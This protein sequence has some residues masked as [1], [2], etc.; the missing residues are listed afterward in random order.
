MMKQDLRITVTKRIMQEALLQMLQKKPIDK[1]KVNELCAECGLNRAT[2]Y[3]HYETVNEIL[4]EIELDFIHKMPDPCNM[5]SKKENF[6]VLAEDICQYFYANSNLV[7]ILLKNRSDEE[8]SGYIDQIFHAYFQNLKK[9]AYFALDE[10]SE[11]VFLAVLGG[12]GQRLLRK[13]IMGEIHK[14][15]Q[16]IAT[17]LC[18][19]A[20]WVQYTNEMC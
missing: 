6:Q 3:R 17:I 11:M 5:I 13:W 16:E 12:G 15:P 14:T 7:K 1:I 20:R 19:F 8:L 10:E 9:S 4:K 2:F 18:D